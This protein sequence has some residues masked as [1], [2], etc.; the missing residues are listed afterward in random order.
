MLR[1]IEWASGALAGVSGLLLPGVALLAISTEPTSVNLRGVLFLLFISFTLLATAAGAYLHSRGG[2]TAG[3]L[4]LWVCT[5]ILAPFAVVS[6]LRVVLVPAFL[7]AL[8]AAIS[9]SLAQRRGAGGR[10]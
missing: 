5:A 7:L 3:L 6:M 2:L 1:S 8:M 10:D 4:Q 9:G